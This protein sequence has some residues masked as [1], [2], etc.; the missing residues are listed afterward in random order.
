MPL[1]RQQPDSCLSY[2]FSAV[3]RV[4]DVP[5]L[6]FLTEPSAIAT[7]TPPGELTSPPLTRFACSEVRFFA[8][9]DKLFTFVRFLVLGI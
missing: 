6:M 5:S 3:K 7:F 2:F 9:F 1:G 8:V 4:F